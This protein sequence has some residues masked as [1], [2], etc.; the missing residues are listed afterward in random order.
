MGVSRKLR[1]LIVEDDVSSARALAQ[2]LRDD[3][4]EVDVVL[5]GA[6]AIARLGRSPA[7][8]VLVADYRLPHADGLAVAAYARSLH[9]PLHVVLITAY[10]ELVGRRNAQLDPPAV[11]FTKP[12]VYADL[13]REL[14]RCAALA[15]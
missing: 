11:I 14:E 1:V 4:Y 12:L 10:S 13:A 6:A 15:V 8:D 7:P 9:Q 3:G 2:M 5:D